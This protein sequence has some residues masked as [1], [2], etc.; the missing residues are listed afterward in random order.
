MEDAWKEPSGSEFKATYDEAI[1]KDK[2]LFRDLARFRVRSPS[3]K[4]LQDF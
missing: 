1:V 2:E 3:R 4:L